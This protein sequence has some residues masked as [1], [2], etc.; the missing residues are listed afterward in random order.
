MIID[1]SMSHK[2]EKDKMDVTN[3]VND[4]KLAD[5]EYYKCIGNA[6]KSAIEENED[7]S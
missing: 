1:D 7:V 4:R 3:E 5:A 6:L 2:I